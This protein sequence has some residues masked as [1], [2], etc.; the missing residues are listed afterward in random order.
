MDLTTHYLGLALRSPLVASSSPM[1][2]D[3]D[4][5]RELADAGV[6]AVVLPSLFEE[7]IHRE[8]LRDLELT[9]GTED[10]VG[11]ASTYFPTVHVDEPGRA[12]RYLR[13][14]ERAV[15]AVDVPVLASLNGSTPGGWVHYARA[16]QD[17]GA[18][19]V[20]LN[21]HPE[22]AEP[23]TD[24]RLVED[25]LVEIV[26]SVKANVEVPVAV[27]LSPWF[28]SVGDVAL[29][30]DR[31]GA[32]GLVLFN[33][34]VHPDVDPERLTVEP[35]VALSTAS[36]ARMPRAWIRLLHGH[37]TGSLGATTG[38]E[39]A[40]DVAAYLLAGADAVMTASAVIRHGPSWASVLL[41]GLEEWGSRH[42]FTSL[43]EVRGR[44]AVPRD[45]DATAYERAG[46]VAALEHG[47]ASWRRHAAR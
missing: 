25:R 27:K 21:I 12:R 37:V 17:A 18:A 40:G 16:M 41:A 4:G 26:R 39:A 35:G 45:T 10:L 15:A 42:G 28:S 9:E 14:L 11:E 23:H 6:G 47:R 5:V 7:E 38:V 33:R 46:Y 2:A 1:T 8:E 20:E 29:R 22:P 24:G 31:A 30:L 3:V 19:A 36:E 43:D 13:T 44:L 34:F 32:D